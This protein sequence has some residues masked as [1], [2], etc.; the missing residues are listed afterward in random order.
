MQE[1]NTVKT[2][3]LLTEE[4]VSKKFVYLIRKG[5]E[6]CHQNIAIRNTY[7]TFEVNGELWCTSVNV[8]FVLDKAES[9][10]L[11]NSNKDNMYT[12]PDKFENAALFLLLGIPCTLIRQ[13]RSKTPLQTGGRIRKRWV[14]VFD[15]VDGQHFEN[16]A[17]RQRCS[18][19]NYDISLTEFP[20]TQIQNDRWLLRFLWNTFGVVR[21]ENIGSFSE[22]NLRFQIPLARCEWGLCYK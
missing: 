21:T 4:K 6:I 15:R 9:T 3:G 12:P 11:I 19:D 8:A 1:A 18:H 7:R 20:Q 5:K 10:L 2:S 14:F 22:W 13:E 16:E 17:F